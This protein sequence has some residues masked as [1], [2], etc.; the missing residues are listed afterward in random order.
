MNASPVGSRNTRSNVIDFHSGR[1]SR[2]RALQQVVRIAPELDGLEVLYSN[3]AYT[4]KLFTARIACW[5]LQ[6]S[7]QVVAMVPW[8]NRIIPCTQI[9][10]PGKIQFEGYYDRNR[11]NIFFEAP[12]HKVTEL[13]CARDYFSD[14]DP[15]APE[16]VLQEIPDS[17]G[18]HA[19]LANP[20][21][22][23]LMLM[24]ILSWRLLGDGSL[25]AML[26]DEDAVESTPVLPGDAC[27]YRADGHHNF[28][29]YFQH[30]IANQIKAEDPAAL[31]AISLLLEG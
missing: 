3:P 16:D 21:G 11:D 6:R 26:V 31:A 18:T 22:G 15:A 7:G 17:T 12:P 19:M 14:T 30:H 13:T 25:H 4:D 24:E 1:V 20:S 5:A 9:S 28:R 29:F 23:R 27:L 2:S 10:Q 8:V